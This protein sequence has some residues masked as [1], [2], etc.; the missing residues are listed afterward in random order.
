MPVRQEHGHGLVVLVRHAPDAI[1]HVEQVAVLEHLAVGFDLDDV[2]G[3]AIPAR[4]GE[5]ER[6]PT[7]DPARGHFGRTSAK[8][9]QQGRK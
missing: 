6:C 9:Q 3:A 8:H 7:F 5:H 2:I 4:V 1:D